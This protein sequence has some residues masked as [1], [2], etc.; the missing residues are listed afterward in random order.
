MSLLRFRARNH[1][2]Q[3][4]QRT[5]DDRETPDD[6]FWFWQE[7]WRFTIDA[8]ADEW[9]AKLPRFWT[10]DDNALAK[11]WAGERVWCNPPYSSIEPWL[12]KAW[13]EAPGS[14]RE[15][16]EYAELVVMLLPAN[17]TE[18]G[19]WQRHIESPRRDGLLEVEFLPGRIKFIGPGDEQRKPNDR[20]PF[21]SCLVIWG[22]DV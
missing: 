7:R 21:G 17:R 16:D 8:A 11:S 10:R 2:Q 3:R 20:P 5:V 4:P 19:W 1:P 13:Q 9:N 14:C 22:D 18:Q 15:S 12:V 6:L